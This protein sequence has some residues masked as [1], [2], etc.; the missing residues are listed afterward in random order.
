MTLEEN[1]MN[2]YMPSSIFSELECCE[3]IK[4]T[5]RDLVFG[6]LFILG[7]SW[8][9]GYY[10]RC[11]LTLSDFKEGLG[12]SRLDKRTNY[13]FKVGGVLD[14]QGYTRASR[15]PPVSFKYE[16]GIIT[17]IYAN[18][19]EKESSEE[20]IR[21]YINN[22]NIKEPLFYENNSKNNFKGMLNLKLSTFNFF[23]NLYDNRKKGVSLFFLYAFLLYMYRVNNNSLFQCSNDTLQK[24]MGWSIKKT[25][26]STNALEQLGLIKK[27]QEKRAKG[28]I[29]TYILL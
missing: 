7:I 6:Y 1:R 8:K 27:E 5:H 3:D 26:A 11:K 2:L 10:A 13:L 12:Y 15:N 24:Y 16:D 17:H 25:I 4:P 28:N 14:A 20:I 18:D 19:L 23:L 9:Y 21:E 22:C 29:N